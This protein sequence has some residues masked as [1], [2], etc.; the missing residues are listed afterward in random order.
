MTATRTPPT[1]PAPRRAARPPAQRPPAPVR[2]AMPDPVR[3]TL[4]AMLAAALGIVPLKGLFSD[5][6]W[7]IDVWLSIVVVLGPALHALRH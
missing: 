7:L 3:R 1:S 5:S 4:L 2:R 6:G